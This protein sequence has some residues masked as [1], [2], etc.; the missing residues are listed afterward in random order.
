MNYFEFL[1][2]PEGLKA[3]AFVSAFIILFAFS[4]GAHPFKSKKR[5]ML[6]AGEN[7]N[8][9]AAGDYFTFLSSLIRSAPTLEKLSETMLLIDGFFDK[10]FRVPISN[11]QLKSYYT[12]LLEVYC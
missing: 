10:P 6:A 2:T 5:L 4:I 7:E 1:T 11:Y 3:T 9:W 12:R 8:L